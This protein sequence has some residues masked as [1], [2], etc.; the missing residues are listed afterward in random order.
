MWWVPIIGSKIRKQF[1]KVNIYIIFTSFKNLQSILCQ[2]KPKLL[3]NSHPGVCQLD[4]SCN[5]R[6][7]GFL[8]Q[9]SLGAWRGL[10][11]Q[12]RYEASGDLWVKNVKTQSLTS[13]EWGAPLTMAQ[14]WPWGSQ[15]AVKIN[16]YSKEWHFMNLL[17][18]AKIW[19]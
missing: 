18:Q 13:S 2:N 1:K 16:N 7:I 17:T 5:S 12:P 4:C 19:R 10:G 6:Y 9:T 8:I 14:S 15:I 3:P 11:T